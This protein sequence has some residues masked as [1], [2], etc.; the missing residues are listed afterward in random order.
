VAKST[1]VPTG[2]P[3]GRPRKPEVEKQ[4]IQDVVARF[5]RPGVDTRHMPLTAICPDCFPEGWE[6]PNVN[7]G[8]ASRAVCQHGV[9]VRRL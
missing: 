5:S 3:P 7:L 6:D 1:Y 4:G 9:W 2:R 8:P